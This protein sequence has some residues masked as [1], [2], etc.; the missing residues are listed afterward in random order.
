MNSWSTQTGVRRL[1]GLGVERFELPTLSVLL[2]F[3]LGLRHVGAR[4]TTRKSTSPSDLTDEQWELLL[5]CLTLMTEEA[6]QR[7][8]EA[9]VRATLQS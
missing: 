8:E 5:P 2:A 4:N 1:I 9:P 6:P 3:L 7:P